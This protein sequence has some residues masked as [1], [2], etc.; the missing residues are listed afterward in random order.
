VYR[1]LKEA[2]REGRRASI[3]FDTEAKRRQSVANLTANTTGEYDSPV[4][5]GP[6]SLTG[7]GCG[8]RSSASPASR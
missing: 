7:P 5:A 4:R 8:T 1:S 2:I 6:P 3:L